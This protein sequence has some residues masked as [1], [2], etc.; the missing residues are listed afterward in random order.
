MDLMLTKVFKRLRIVLCNILRV[1][2]GNDEV[3]ENRGKKGEKLRLK[4]Q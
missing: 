2:G 4:V 3:E 1:E